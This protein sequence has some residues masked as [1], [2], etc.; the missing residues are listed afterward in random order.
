MSKKSKLDKQFKRERKQRDQ[1][2]DL[3][4]RDVNGLDVKFSAYQD[5]HQ[6]TDVV[7]YVVFQL[8]PG[9]NALS[10]DVYAITEF[11]GPISDLAIGYIRDVRPLRI[12]EAA[13]LF[14]DVIKLESVGALLKGAPL[15]DVET[16][17]LRVPLWGIHN[18]RA[19]NPNT[20]DEV[21]LP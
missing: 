4:Q 18:V 15:K 2:V 1:L 20:D 16:V 11:E 6:D 19:V 14:L 7:D 13:G 12:N 8:A 3:L 5:M 9:I 17:M 21:P 10:L